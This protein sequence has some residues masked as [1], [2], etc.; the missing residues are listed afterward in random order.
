MIR[1]EA[2]ISFFSNLNRTIFAKHIKCYTFIV[3]Y[4]IY[5]NWKQQPVRNETNTPAIKFYS[6]TRTELFFKRQQDNKN[7]FDEITIIFFDYYSSNIAWFIVELHILSLASS[8][9]L[10]WLKSVVERPID[11]KRAR[12]ARKF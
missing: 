7:E 2:E 6:Q 3:R 11:P 9:S 1:S 10:P 12:N 4:T 5:C 8:V